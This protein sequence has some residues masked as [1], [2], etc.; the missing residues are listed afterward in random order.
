VKSGPET[1]SL[2]EGLSPLDVTLEQALALLA[3]PKAG[4]RGPTKRREPLK[5]FEASPATGKPV[6]LLE[7]R[8]GPYVT[9]GETNASLPKSLPPQELTFQ[10]A[11]DLLKAR[12]ER[13]PSPAGARRPARKAA[14]KKAT[15]AAIGAGKTAAQGKAAKKKAAPKRSKKK[16]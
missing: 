6:E 8:Y 4:R 15:S 13:G 3:Q 1:R 5:V 12:A 11:L 9:D 14:T 2:A 10:A 7:G 16:S